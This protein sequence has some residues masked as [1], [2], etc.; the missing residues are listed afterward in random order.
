MFDFS[1]NYFDLFGLPVGFRV[2]GAA[3][4]ERY[5]DLQKVV[6][7]DRYANAPEAEQRLALQ[8]ATRV[9]EAFETLRDP[10]QRARYLLQLNGMDPDQET[11]TTRD[12]EFLMQ[13]MELR[14]S[15]AEVRGQADPQALGLV[16]SL[17]LPQAVRATKAEQRFEELEAVLQQRVK[18]EQRKGELR[19]HREAKARRPKATVEAAPTDSAGTADD[20]GTADT[21]PVSFSPPATST[22]RAMPKSATIA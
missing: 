4:A 7:P 19:R 22:A 20:T 1:K 11:A 14:E 18:W 15:L 3:L 13:Q 10:L 17:R 5:R 2:D 12:T 16:R 6:H 8:Q 21:P 9:N